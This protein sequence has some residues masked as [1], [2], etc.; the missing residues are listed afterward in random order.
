MVPEELYSYARLQ[1]DIAGNLLSAFKGVM[2]KDSNGAGMIWNTPFSQFVRGEI[3]LGKTWIWGRSSNQSIATRFV[4]GAGHAYGNS[5]ALPFEKHFYAGGANSLRGWQARTVGPGLSQRDTTFV[6]PNQTGDM[7]LE[8]NVEYRFHMLWKLDGA[9]FIDAGNVWTLKK[10]SEAENDGSLF[11]W[12]TFGE[13]IAANWGAGIRLDL[14][15][16]LLRVDC[17]FKVHDPARENKWMGP[18]YWFRKNGFAIHFGV[19]YP[20]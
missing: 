4:A 13:S 9:V 17:G 6:I 2:E 18:A 11:R 19:G 1:F 7:R 3:T 10:T 14:D 16:L 20:F 8:A 12:N 15:F 5:T